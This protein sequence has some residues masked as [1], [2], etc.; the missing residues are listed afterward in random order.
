[1]S[2]RFDEDVFA[3]SLQHEAP[4]VARAKGERPW[5]LS[6]QFYVGF[7]GGALAVSAL[8]WLNAER[9][10]APPDPRRWI[11]LLGVLGVVASVVVS[12]ALYGNDYGRGARIGFRVGGVIIAGAVS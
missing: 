11:A 12:Y 8:A 2:S 6:S 1:M 10:D 9:L 7:F 4:V 3:P 5:R